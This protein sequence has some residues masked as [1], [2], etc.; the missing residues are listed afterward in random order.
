M[1]AIVSVLGPFSSATLS[2]WSS[3]ISRVAFLNSLI[4]LPSPAASSGIFLDPK[5]ISTIST[6]MMSSV[7]PRFPMKPS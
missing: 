3:C 5:N 6:M 7:A 2:S 4:P 1:H